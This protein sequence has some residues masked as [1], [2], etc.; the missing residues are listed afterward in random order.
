MRICGFPCWQRRRTPGPSR[1]EYTSRLARWSKFRCR[2]VADLNR[3]RLCP[4]S[5]L[6]DYICR[7]Q[8][9]RRSWGIPLAQGHYRLNQCQDSRVLARCN[10]RSYKFH[11]Y[12]CREWSRFV[13]HSDWVRPN[14]FSESYRKFRPAPCSWRWLDRDWAEHRSNRWQWCRC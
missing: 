4:R 1:L 2:S 11:P 5:Y 7:R 8:K 13:G 6:I 10:C 3:P 12:L 14:I 9:R